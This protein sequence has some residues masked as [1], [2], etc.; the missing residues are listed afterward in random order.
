M[1]KYLPYVVIGAGVLLQ[2]FLAF[3]SLPFIISNIVPDDGFY[4]FQIA[5]NIVH[6]LGSTF[7]GV[8][9][10]NGYHPLWMLVLLPIFAIFS[11]GGTMDVA[12]IHVALA[13]SALISGIT[14]LVLLALIRRYTEDYR[15]QTLALA[16]WFFNPFVVYES[17]SGL[18]TSLSLCLISLFLFAAVRYSEKQGMRQLVITGI[19]GGFMMLA[20]LDNLMYFV[21]FLCWLPYTFGMRKGVRSAFFAGIAASCIV[22][23]WIVWNYA[24]F[25]MLLTSASVTATVVNHHLVAQDN[26][27]GFFQIAKA[28]IYTINLELRNIVSETG[29]PSL[30]LMLFGAVL[31]WCFFNRDRVR[32][33]MRDIPVEWMVFAGFMMVF[34]SNAAIRWT[35]RSWYF[36]AANLFV[37]LLLAWYTAEL[38]KKRRVPSRHL[39]G[40]AACMIAIFFI[41]WHAE[42]RG[43]ESAQLDMYAATEWMNENLPAGA[44]IG[45]F[46]SGV[47]AY[48]SNHRVV[49]IDG[50]VNN[51]ASRAML[52]KDLWAYIESEKIAYIADFDIYMTYRYRDFLGVPN[53]FDK[54]ALV[55]TINVSGFGRAENGIHI[56]QVK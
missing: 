56:Y 23:P 50:L 11:Q 33:L 45:I 40:V 35:A 34:I 4:Y 31:A 48:F 13:L 38:D 18:E 49:N 25:G 2:L 1:K 46:N 5:R 26:G 14:G 28:T 41:N 53:I 8:N 21:A 7:D 32:E 47:Q 29:A 27:T 43:R 9:L 44:T 12:P 30:V 42:L 37:S 16:F 3:R 24:T 19:I 39:I 6:G 22:V 55:H 52:N 36:M 10:T 20:R 54:L 17:L 51:A 15:I